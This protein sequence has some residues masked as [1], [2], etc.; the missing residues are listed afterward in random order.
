MGLPCAVPARRP[1]GAIGAA[2]AGVLVLGT[3]GAVWLRVA[4]PA[5]PVAPGA[6]ATVALAPS[7]T[8]K[9]LWRG[10]GHG[11]GMSQYGAAARR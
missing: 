5:R 6:V 11:H 2:L 1:V 9:V 4:A 10:N 7:G 8:V 3:L